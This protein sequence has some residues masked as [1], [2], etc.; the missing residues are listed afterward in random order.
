MD[1]ESNKYNL[2]KLISDRRG[3][4]VDPQNNQ[5]ALATNWARIQ[6]A[7][8]SPGS[9]GDVASLPHWERRALESSVAGGDPQSFDQTIGKSA[10]NQ[11]ATDAFDNLWGK[12]KADSKKPFNR[13]NKEDPPEGQS[14]PTS[15]N[16]QTVPEDEEL[17]DDLDDDTDTDDDTTSDEKPDT[18]DDDEQDK[19]TEADEDGNKPKDKN[20]DEPKPGEP[21][22]PKPNNVPVLGD[23]G[24]EA[25]KTGA[26]TVATTGTDAV[27][28][29]GGE[30]GVT[31]AAA[32]IGG[33][34]GF[35]TLGLALAILL[36]FG[37]VGIGMYAFSLLFSQ[38][39]EEAGAATTTGTSV[40]CLDPGHPSEKSGAPGE[41][42][43]NYKIAT[44]L[45][46]LLETEGYIVTMTKSSVD[47]T[48]LNAERAKRCSDASASLM[49]RI[50]ADG[51]AYSA[52]YPYHIIPNPDMT[53]I[54]TNSKNYSDAIQSNLIKTLKADGK[55]DTSPFEATESS[56]IT[57][58]DRGVSSG[59]GI[60][61]VLDASIAANDLKMPS[62]LIEAIQLDASGNSWLDDASNRESFVRG[63]SIGISAAVP[64]GG[65]SASAIVDKAC[66]LIGDENRSL[67]ESIMVKTFTD[68][69]G[70]VATVVK[71]SVDPAVVYSSTAANAPRNY[72]E[73]VPEKYSIQRNVSSTSGLVPGDLLFSEGPGSHASIYVGSGGCGCSGNAVSASLDSHGPLCSNWYSDMSTI[74]RFK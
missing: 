16:R 2:S 41:N 45:K 30:A 17:D 57:E 26:K 36:V 68:C 33:E 74:V 13:W 53:N 55:Y 71:N 35:S 25:A 40:I 48:V 65:G 51:S 54:Y 5:A 38:N 11:S 46:P 12:T 4:L 20:P 69:F 42:E 62:T 61:G 14:Q 63:L 1:Q 59:T 6:T 31:G 43:L 56:V 34:A 32:L 72:F 18:P 27:A 23:S 58:K 52:G 37:A 47:E 8:N 9:K 70:F 21:E 28:G 15:D 67:Y 60:D 39:P 66:Q 19:R 44:E 64:K 22:T 10:I 73:T 49:Y 3:L 7:Y 24:P 29:V 50:H